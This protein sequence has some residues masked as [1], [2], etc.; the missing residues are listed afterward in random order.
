[1]AISAKKEA[2]KSVKDRAKKLRETISRHSRLYH[3]IDK[4]EIS[5]TAYDEL[6]QELI[7]L[8]AEYPSLKNTDSPTQRVGGEPLKEFKKVKHKFPQWSFNDVFSPE[9]L[10]EF[11]ARTK[12]FLKGQTPTYACELKIDGLKVIFEYQKGIFKQAAT[13]GDGAM[14]E[15]VTLNVRTI[16]S[17]PLKL[18]KEIDIIVEGEVWMKKSTLISLNKER[19]KKGEEPF[20]NPRNVA[21]GSIRQL[22]PKI[23]ASRKLETYIY[24]IAVSS[25][26]IPNE[27]YQELKFLEELGFKVNPH[28]KHVNSIDD[29]ISYW[30]KWRESSKKEDYQVDGIVLKVNERKLQERLGY[31]GKAPR[32]AVAFKFPA[33]QVTTVVE[34]IKVQVG[35]T[36]A[37]TPVAHLKPVLVY[38]SVVSRATL[39]NE[40]EIERLD[41][42]IG[43]TVILQKA[44][45]VIP[46]IVS[47]LK[48]M[49]TGKEKVFSFPKNCPECGSSVQKKKIGGGGKKEESAA[50]YCFNKKCPAK[51]R[52]RLYHF[53]SKKALNIEGLG[54]KIID[55]LVE[56]NLVSSYD[57]FFTL[58]KGDLMALPRFAEKSADNLLEEI[59]KARDV[60]LPRFIV[61]LSIPQVGEETAYDLAEHFGDI[62]FLSFAKKEELMAIEGVGETVADSI[63]SWF[64]DAHNKKLLEDLLAFVSVKNVA[65][66]KKKVGR[67]G[68]KVLV[69]TGTFSSLSRDEAKEIV[70]KQGGN[71]SGSVSKSTDFIVVGEN[72]GSKLSEAKKL[73]VPIISEQEFLKML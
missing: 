70:R 60:E 42:R 8:E 21:A 30:N 13:R 43:D 38:G 27:Q 40:D 9:E 52:R 20:A 3:V 10:V 68:G 41:V 58:K 1:M 29:A 57:D 59:D 61:A 69:I 32:F 16:E 48:E 6:E 25:V 66:S 55:L 65:V 7:R 53:A 19:L 64:D 5:D 18:S 36:G 14:G 44:G 17:V 33:E 24:D 12:R 26:S 37:L 67:L 50:Y 34:D 28:F 39:H 49:R 31:T 46:D 56:N 63:I 45:D 2:S 71:V 62:K 11:N 35:R 54:P 23:A 73:G 22:D 15:D 4:P 72:P 47:A 51:D